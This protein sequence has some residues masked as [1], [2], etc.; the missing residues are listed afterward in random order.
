MCKVL[1]VG[2]INVDVMMGGLASF[3]MAD[4]EITCDSFDVVMGSSAVIAACTCS[5]RPAAIACLSDC[6][7]AAMRIVPTF[8][9]FPTA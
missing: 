8:Y 7:P 3:P 5:S 6:S 4:K 2:D 9:D 1:Y